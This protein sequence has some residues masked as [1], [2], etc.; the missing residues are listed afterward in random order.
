MYRREVRANETG[1][2]RRVP[3]HIKYQ[4]TPMGRNA[5]THTHRHKQLHTYIGVAFKNGIPQCH[6]AITTTTSKSFKFKTRP[7]R[8]VVQRRIKRHK[9][10]F[11]SATAGQYATCFTACSFIY[12]HPNMHTNSPKALF[13]TT[14]IDSSLLS[15]CGQLAQTSS[16]QWVGMD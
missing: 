7:I 14:F 5:E 11:C 3:R 8:P 9:S 13:H 4:N 10:Q 6:T 2:Q 12:T 16:A 1:L 15:L